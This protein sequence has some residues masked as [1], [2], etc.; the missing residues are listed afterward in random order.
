MTDG[1]LQAYRAL[2]ERGDIHPDAAQFAVVERLQA[3]SAALAAMGAANNGGVLKA[4][5]GARRGQ[6]VPKGVYLHGEVGRGKSMLMDLF[7]ETAPVPSKRRVHFHA[8]MQEVHRLIHLER[9]QGKHTQDSDV[10]KAVAKGVARESS[11]L[12]F[13]ELHVTDIADAM[14]LGRLFKKLFERDIVMVATSNRPPADLYKGG[15]NRELFLPFI[16]MIE[17]KLDVVRLDAEQ[18]YR[19]AFLQHANVYNTPLGDEATR[20]LDDT[21]EH[22]VGGEPPKPLDLEV[23]G[24]TLHVPRQARHV[25]RFS[26]DELCNRPLGAADY[27]LLADQFHT[28]VIDDIPRMDSTRRNEA[29]RFATLIDVLYE[30]RVNLVCSAEALPDD[31]YVQ[32]DGAFEFQRT[33]SRLI[34]MRSDHYLAQQRPEAA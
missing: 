29:A 18:D 13:D 27:L 19:L 4:F 1:P 12:C 16:A 8:F 31:L 15:I 20:A 6:P 9:N 25:A 32:G 14:I 2:I 5:F 22:L 28:V 11:L 30:N 24:R 7:Y 3:L 23:Q 21:F 34:E 26:F 17:E 33:A 10:I